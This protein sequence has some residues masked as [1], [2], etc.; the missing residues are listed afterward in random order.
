[1]I[2]CNTGLNLLYEPI[3]VDTYNIYIG[4]DILHNLASHIIQLVPANKY[5]LI[6]DDNLLSSYAQSIQHSF[7]LLDIQL[8][9]YSITPGEHSKSRASKAAIED[10]MLLQQCGRDTCMLALGGGVVG[11]LT[12]YIAATYMRG[13]SVIQIPTSLLAMVDSSI[14]GKTGIDT[15]NGKN[16]LGAFHRPRAVYIDLML[17]QTLPDRQL[18]NGMA[19]SIKAGAIASHELFTLI[20]LN[21]DNVMKRDLKLLGDIVYRSASIKARVVL[22]DEHEGGLRS[23]LNYG[24]S[25][26]HA[27]EAYCQPEL[28]HGECVGI[29]MIEE[30][31]LAR[32]LGYLSSNAAIQRIDNC[33]KLYNLPTSVPHK[34]N[35]SI[36]GLLNKMSVDKKNKAG[37]KEIVM[38]TSIGTI[39]SNPYTTPI[40]DTVLLKLFH[41][42]ITVQPAQAN[43]TIQV[44]GSKSLSNR[45]LLLAALGNGQCNI[46]GLLHSNDTQVMLDSL[47]ELGVQYSWSDDQSILTVHGTAGILTVPNRSLNLNNAGTASRFLTSVA[48]LVPHG[49]VVLT[50]NQRMQQR[51]ITDLVD[52]LSKAGI[53]IE[54]LNLDGCLPIRVSGGGVSG[55]TIELKANVSSQY[56]SSIM[57][58]ATYAKS[59]TTLKLVGEC[60]SKPFIYMAMIMY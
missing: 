26:G 13:I 19:E 55:G 14:G 43:G 1:M 30:G 3:T 58:A 6:T 2:Q 36:N 54:Y 33:L 4:Q 37:K 16:L 7:L 15:L 11:D 8:L 46:R 42:S 23:I 31:I 50:G 35:L 45:V 47:R 20:E 12:G 60:V 18:C 32:Q 21:S 44:P 40:S 28:L 59:T 52:A 53:H 17:L 49:T 38:L 48:A 57:Q 56:V 51:P 24:H 41:P 27:V 29:G 34:F 9:I 25:I 10:Y 22:Q 39:R 5:I